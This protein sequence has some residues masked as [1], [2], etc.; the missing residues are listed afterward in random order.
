MPLGAAAEVEP[1]VHQW[2][3]EV[4]GERRGI[5]PAPPQRE[6]SYREAGER[7]RGVV[8]DPIGGKLKGIKQVFV[9]P[10]GALHLVNLSTL[11]QGK[12]RYLIETGPLISYLTA[13]RD[14]IRAAENDSRGQ[15]ALVM[16]GPDFDAVD[17][18]GP[19]AIAA[20]VSD[21]SA[22]GHAGATYRS[23]KPSC[24]GFLAEPFE[25]LPG[26]VV[27]AEE[28]GSLLR[29]SD[30]VRGAGERGVMM[31][32]GAA[33]QEA[34]F[35]RLAP[36]RRIIHL[37]THG[38]FAQNTCRSAF[39]RDEGAAAVPAGGL[40]NPLL[41]SGVV[42]AGANHRRETG[43]REEDEDGILTAEEIA[44]IDL[45]GVDWAVL[46]ACETGLGAIQQGEGV[47]GLRRAFQV[48]G[49]STLIMSLWRVQD[50]EA[51]EWMRGLYEA[52]LSGLST[53]ESV[54]RASL[55]MIDAR[56][57]SVAGTHPSSWGAFVATGDWR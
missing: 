31:L 17:G 51:R 50:Q 25:P 29:K 3:R 32:E 38:F 11:P 48:A 33:A 44:A 34:A 9:V 19:Q 47:L 57:D 18:A 6:A 40:D 22:Q 54:R 35:K 24:T 4:A 56:R 39:D 53:A 28:V 10:D 21:G 26:S 13:E 37:A 27:E 52:R 42:L 30:H 43:A 46:S 1:A 15:G 41:L 36:G 45:S 12:G 5:G 23:P 20:V 14:L 2:R 7:L 8:W 16:G 49:A 55:K